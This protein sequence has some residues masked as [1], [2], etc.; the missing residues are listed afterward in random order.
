[1]RFFYG[2][3]L[4]QKETFERIVSGKKPE[5]LPPVLNLEETAHFLEAVTGLRN[6]VALMTQ[7]IR[8]TFNAFKEAVT[9][10]SG[11]LCLSGSVDRRWSRCQFA[12]PVL[13]S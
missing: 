13:C 1:L 10:A 12:W 7:S 11:T 9:K 5:K 6:R 4:G 8:P 3:T 2:I